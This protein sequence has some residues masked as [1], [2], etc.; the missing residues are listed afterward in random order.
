MRPWLPCA[1]PGET[2]A[3][4]TEDVTFPLQRLFFRSIELDTSTAITSSTSTG[5]ALGLLSANTA[6][7]LGAANPQPAT[8]TAP[9]AAKIAIKV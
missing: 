2:R 1:A 5:M 9:P 8:T 3:K 7:G 4:S 6:S